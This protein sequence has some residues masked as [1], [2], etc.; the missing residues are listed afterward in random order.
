VISLQEEV[1][2]GF[3]EVNDN[4]AVSYWKP[5]GAVISVFNLGF[6]ADD[7]HFDQLVLKDLIFNEGDTLVVAMERV[8][9]KRL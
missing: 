8:S 3:G 6:D 5:A 9:R 7:T 2:I 4:V 1:I